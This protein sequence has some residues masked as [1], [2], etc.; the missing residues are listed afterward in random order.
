MLALFKREKNREGS[1]VTCSLLGAGV[2]ALVNQ[3]SGY[4]MTGKIPERIGSDHPSIAPY[5]TV[6]YAQEEPLVLAVGNNR[7]FETLAKILEF[8]T[9]GFETNVNRCTRREELKDIIAGKLKR[10]NREQ[11]LNAA[12][13]AQVPAGA[14]KNMEEVFHHPEAQRMIVESAEQRVVRQV[15]WEGDECE[16][17]GPAPE[18]PEKSRL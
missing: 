10:W 3:A 12:W 6:F 7:Q 18:S 14:V 13:K 9:T 4:L 1:Y 15:A 11:F 8:P 5:G 17:L 2:S 16:E